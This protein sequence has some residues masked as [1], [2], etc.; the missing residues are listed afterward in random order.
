MQTLHV[1]D[2][3]VY[4][5]GSLQSLAVECDFLSQEDEELEKEEMEHL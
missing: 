1:D 2:L 3:N 4:R 5:P